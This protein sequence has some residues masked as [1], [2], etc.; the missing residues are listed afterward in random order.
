MPRRG[1]QSGHYSRPLV[2][3][4]VI[5]PYHLPTWILTIKNTVLE[6]IILQRTCGDSYQLNMAIRLE[7]W[8]K[9]EVLIVMW[10]SMKGM[11]AEKYVVKPEIYRVHTCGSMVDKIYSKINQ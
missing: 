10:F 11:S 5:T 4:L 7:Q 2:R 3:R 9:H 1:G 8:S 6:V